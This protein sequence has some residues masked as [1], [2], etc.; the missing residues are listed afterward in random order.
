[1]QL[2]AFFLDYVLKKEQNEYMAENV[3]SSQE[4]IDFTGCDNQMCLDLIEG[5]VPVPGI[6]HLLDEADSMNTE[7][8]T[9]SIAR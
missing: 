6:I 1:M 4:A 5:V 3:V 2:Q 8:K 9:R 7:L